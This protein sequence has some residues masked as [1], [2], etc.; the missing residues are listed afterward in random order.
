MQNSFPAGAYYPNMVQAANLFHQQ[1]HG[2]VQHNSIQAAAALIHQQNPGLQHGQ[3]ITQQNHAVSQQHIG[4]GPSQPQPSGHTAP[5]TQ[6]ESGSSAQQQAQVSSSSSSSQPHLGS[7]LPPIHLAGVTSLTK[8][9]KLI[10]F[11]SHN[12]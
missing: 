10:V 8:C 11:A 6:P 3:A 12:P 2:V 5:V 4:A 9:K 1:Q 7:S